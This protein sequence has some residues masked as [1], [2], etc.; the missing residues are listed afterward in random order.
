[1]NINVEGRMYKSGSNVYIGYMPVPVKDQRG[2]L[3]VNYK[4]NQ[5]NI[6]DI[7]QLPP[8]ENDCVFNYIFGGESVT[9]PCPAMDYWI[10]RHRM[11]NRI[12]IPDYIKKFN[13]KVK[14]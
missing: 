1:M 5:V 11:G 10:Y 7:P 6:K 14:Y 3:Y 4:G 12:S 9:H 2:R 8:P 13:V